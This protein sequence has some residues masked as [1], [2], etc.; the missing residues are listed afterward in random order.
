MLLTVWGLGTQVEGGVMTKVGKAKPA[1]QPVVIGRGPQ[2]FIDDYLIAESRGIEKV[3]QHPARVLDQPVMGWQQHT[4]Q[5]YVTVL[6]DADSGKFRMW[7]NRDGGVNTA[8]AYA[9]SEDGVHWTMPVLNILGPDNRVMLIG[10]SPEN[11][12]Y[13]VSVID[14]GARA[15]D[16]SRRFK[17]MW[18]SGTSEPPGASVAWS[19]DG[20]HWNAYEKNPVVPYYPP[21]SAKA[22]IGVGDIVDLFY[23]SVRGRYASLLKLHALK[24]DGWASGPRAGAAIRRLVG[25]SVSDDFLHWSEP[26]RVIVPEPRDKGLLEFYS[27]GGVI[28]RGPLLIAFV[29]MLHD[30]YSPEPGGEAT[31]IGYTT[32]ATSRDGERWERQDDIFFDRDPVSGSWDRAMTWVGCAVPVGEELYLYYGGYKRGH[33]IEPTKERQIGLAKMRLDRFVARE[34]RG[35]AA[36][37]LTT[38]P[39]SFGAR[40]GG[41]LTV[42]ADA[43]GGQLRAQVRDAAGAVIDG[44][45]FNDCQ[46]IT[47]DGIALPLRWKSAAVK[48]IGGRVVRLEFELTRAKLFGFELGGT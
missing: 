18:W 2:L 8:I 6:R 31:G 14:D 39:L 41:Q 9:D 27:A 17:M 47:G 3:T 38:V 19:A 16:G 46:P 34:G 5:P 1:T 12:S 43:S 10:R 35:D 13:G 23:D 20:L 48:D 33:K 45:S 25:E 37:V 28:A 15:K 22:A 29:R 40:P 4:T 11:G 26:W 30:D 44:L 32:L 36:G 42:N 21:G 7:Y 24:S